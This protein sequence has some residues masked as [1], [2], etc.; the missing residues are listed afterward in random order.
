MLAVMQRDCTIRL[1]STDD[2]DGLARLGAVGSSA[3]RGAVVV[4][5]VDG[6]PVAAVGL[7]DGRVAA[8]PARSSPAILTALRLRRW[9]TWL[10]GAIWG[11]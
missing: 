11:V 1:S 9:E 10:I 6:S 8:D 2:D 4:A 3:P 7:A 5:D